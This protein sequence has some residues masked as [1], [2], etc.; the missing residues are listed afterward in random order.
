MLEAVRG[1]GRKSSRLVWARK[2]RPL[3]TPRN[4][5]HPKSTVSRESQAPA[6]RNPLRPH[7][8]NRVNLTVEMVEHRGCGWLFGLLQASQRAH[9]K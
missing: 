6:L 7:D 4:H 8:L 3:Y 5:L 9:L 2:F 1:G